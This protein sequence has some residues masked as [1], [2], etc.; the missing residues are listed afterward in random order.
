MRE[1]VSIQPFSFIKMCRIVSNVIVYGEMITTHWCTN[2]ENYY[3]ACD[4][5]EAD[6]LAKG[7]QMCDDKAYCFGVMIH[8]NWSMHHKGLKLCTSIKLESKGDWKIVLKGW[9]ILP[10]LV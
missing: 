8:P 6:C 4:G 7:K 3:G 2:Q 5:S 9:L 1:A 10:K